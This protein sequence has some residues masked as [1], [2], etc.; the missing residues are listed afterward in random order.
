MIREP[1]FWFRSLL[2]S[3]IVGWLPLILILIY[4]PY[5]HITLVAA[6]ALYCGFTGMYYKAFDAYQAFGWRAGIEQ[7]KKTYKNV[8]EFTD[9]RWNASKMAKKDIGADKS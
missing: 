1:N 5:Q 4:I 6:V 8:A 9:T 3:L 2:V 7:M